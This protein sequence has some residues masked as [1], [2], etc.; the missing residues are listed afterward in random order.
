MKLA[1]IVEHIYQI[2]TQEDLKILD[3]A[4]KLRWNELIARAARSFK[5]GDRVKFTN[6]KYGMVVTGVITKINQKTIK[7]TADKGGMKWTV[8]PSLL[9]PA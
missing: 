9:S 8:G 4:L 6:R 3:G 7:L 2:E 1:D 5:V